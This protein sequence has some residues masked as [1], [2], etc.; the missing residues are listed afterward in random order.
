VTLH[1]PWSLTNGRSS[2]VDKRSSTHLN[3]ILSYVMSSMSQMEGMRKNPFWYF[4]FDRLWPFNFQFGCQ[5]KSSNHNIFVSAH[6][7]WKLKIVPKISRS[8]ESIVRNPFWYFECFTSG[9]PWESLASPRVNFWLVTS[10]NF[11]DMGFQFFT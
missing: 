11:W 7:I 8:R 10:R 3:L 1:L 4:W 5:P 2:K 6:P 9:K